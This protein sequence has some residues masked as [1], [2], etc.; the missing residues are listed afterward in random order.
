MTK[1]I[2]RVTSFL[3]VILL[4]AAL[5]CIVYIP[6]NQSAAF[7]EETPSW[8]RITKD[9]VNLYATEDCGK[10]ICLLE[11]S[12]YV[13]VAED[14]GNVLRVSIMQNEDD[15]PQIVGYVRKIEVE[16]QEAVP[17]APY[18]PCEKLT[19]IS[20]SASLKLLPLSSSE[21]VLAATNMQ[22]LS[23]YGKINSYGKI[24]YYVYCFGKFGY[25]ETSGV[26]APKIDLHPTPLET[27]PVIKPTDPSND[28]TQDEKENKFSPTAEILLIVFVTL[29][30]AGL[31]L[32][33]FLPGN[34]KK[35][36]VFDQD[37]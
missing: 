31:T 10:S 9:S 28:P 36:N 17:L 11:K 6:F 3:L 35:Q 12:Y 24:W 34:V 21:T 27:K 20:D 1:S 5:I 7:A 33:L 18:Y 26:S 2:L 15:F 16:L 30:A 22:K 19:V 25:I 32:A 29:L 37:I 23:Y 14:L 4:T 8:A 13:S